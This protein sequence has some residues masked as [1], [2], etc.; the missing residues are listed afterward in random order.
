MFKCIYT[1][2][3]CVCVCVCAYVYIWLLCY[4]ITVKQKVIVMKREVMAGQFHVHSHLDVLKFLNMKGNIPIIILFYLI[5]SRC[6]NN[7]GQCVLEE[8]IYFT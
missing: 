1:P 7:C 6:A 2:F 5:I 8:N 3:V 4:L